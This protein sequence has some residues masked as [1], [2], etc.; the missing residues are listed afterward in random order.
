MSRFTAMHLRVLWFTGMLLLA[1]CG[2]AAVTPGVTP[3]VRAAPL[4]QSTV[5]LVKTVGL[6]PGECASTTEVDITA[7]LTV[8]YCYA[9]TNNSSAPIV[10]QTLLD[11]DSPNG[12]TIVPWSAGGSALVGPGATLPRRSHRA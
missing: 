9:L 5:T 8:T 4:Q 10:A 6:K 12:Q 2:V 11:N 3:A 7:G 1:L